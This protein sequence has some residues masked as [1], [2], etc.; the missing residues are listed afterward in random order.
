MALHLSQNN[1]VATHEFFL[2]HRRMND[3]TV[4]VKEGLLHLIRE[5]DQG[6]GRLCAA[7]VVAHNHPS[8]ESTPSPEDVAVTR[9]FV[10]AGK[11]LDIEVIDHIVIGS[12][13]RWVSLKERGLGF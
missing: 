3:E 6:T 4:V 7:V 5:E 9:E 11:I 1:V 12:C 2:G 13:N 10:N 8:G